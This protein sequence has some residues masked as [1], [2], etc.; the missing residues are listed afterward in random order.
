VEADGA[1]PP[2]PS[3]TVDLGQGR[4]AFAMPAAASAVVAVIDTQVVYERIVPFYMNRSL[5]DYPF[6]VAA[7]DGGKILAHSGSFAP[8]RD[9][10]VD[11]GISLQVADFGRPGARGPGPAGNSS[12]STDPL[13]QSWLQRV[14][15]GDASAPAPPD[16]PSAARLQVF[17]PNGTLAAA[18][19]RQQLTSLAVA[20][21]ILGFL[22]ASAVVLARLYRR[23][24]RLRASEREFV[25][26]ISHEL[27][28][29][30]A[31]IQATSE[32]L[33]RGVVS[34]PSRLKKYAD[35]IHGQIRRLSGMVE[36]ILLYSGLLSGR[37]PAPVLS[38][39]DV[40]TLIAE[41][42][43]PLEALAAERG[44]ALRVDTEGIPRQ[45]G[46]DASTLR[47]V[48][49]NLV[50]NAIRHADPG[51][52]RVRAVRRAFDAL[53]VVVEDDGP[54]IPSREQARIFEP[55]VRG[56]RSARAQTAGSGLGLHL[57]RRVVSLVGGTVTLESPYAAISG[58]ARAGCRF[59]VTLP[60]RE[61]GHAG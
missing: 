27:R 29:P 39:V 19:R 14:A 44:S 7:V 45:L 38:D 46:T 55:F 5:P 47:L 3:Q 18:V 51:E 17:Y 57:V 10:E 52:I 9:P 12:R 43:R 21:G 34:D 54:G 49:E 41:T 53:Q 22:A 31:V 59:V 20:F 6:R 15:G 26:S 58:A 30:I 13:L 42:I 25:A 2:R 33:T 8:G 11:V 24:S 4:I 28:T 37:A 32:N 35:V 60:C 50:V 16:L 1:R 48:V 40:A 36:G 23:S 61:P 56:E